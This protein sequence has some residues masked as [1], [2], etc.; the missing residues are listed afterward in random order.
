MQI[1]RSFDPSVRELLVD[2]E[3]MKRVFI[4]LLDNA[5]DALSECD[6]RRIT[7]STQLNRS[8][9]SV[10]IVFSDNGVGIEPAD[11]DNLFL[12]YFSTKKK[13]TGLGLAIV[14]QIISD[15][16]GYIRAEPNQPR[17]TRF[18]MDI[19]LS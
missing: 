4:N 2:A 14:R 19:P 15:H 1:E 18:S 8:R 12:P 7:V 16:N 17:G 13:G 6:D 5:L 10:T 11:Y 3:Q 9:S